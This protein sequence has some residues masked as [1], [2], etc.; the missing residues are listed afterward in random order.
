MKYDGPLYGKIGRRTFDTGKTSADWDALE[1]QIR[2]CS[3]LH[4]AIGVYRAA[5]DDIAELSVSGDVSSY[6]DFGDVA[7]DALLVGA[8]HAELFREKSKQ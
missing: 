1:N 3:K 6:S 8:K 5:L 2:E 7:R 4:L